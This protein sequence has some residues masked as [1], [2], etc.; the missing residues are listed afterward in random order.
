MPAVEAVLALLSSLPFFPAPTGCWQR[1]VPGALTYP[2]FGQRFFCAF[3]SS[4]A[5]CCTVSLNSAR[6]NV[7]RQ[8]FI[9]PAMNPY[10]RGLTKL[11]HSSLLIASASA[12]LLRP[13]VSILERNFNEDIHLFAAGRSSSV[14]HRRCAGFACSRRHSTEHD[15][16]GR[17]RQ[18]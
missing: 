10:R 12:T 18:V 14:P 5:S 8:T 1:Q 6:Q 2:T 4:S 7:N 11:T 16:R 17:R 3:G 9:A 13:G 15:L